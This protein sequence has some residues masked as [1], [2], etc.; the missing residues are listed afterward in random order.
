MVRRSFVGRASIATVR[1]DDWASPFLPRSSILFPSPAERPQAVRVT[2]HRRLTLPPSTTVAQVAVGR[3]ALELQSR[4]LSALLCCALNAIRSLSMI[5][6]VPRI[7]LAGHDR[8][9][10]QLRRLL[11]CRCP[12]ALTGRRT[13]SHVSP[14]DRV[15][16]ARAW[17]GEETKGSGCGVE[18]GR[19]HWTNLSAL[20]LQILLLL[21]LPRKSRD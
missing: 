13:M 20:P 4:T 7:P 15:R 11:H 9:R 16:V 17:V 18:V 10:R 2:L 1:A 12:A 3:A 21:L 14:N 8:R 19:T 6:I 5:T